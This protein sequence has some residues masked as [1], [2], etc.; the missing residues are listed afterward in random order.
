MIPPY[1]SRITTAKLLIES[2]EYEVK[3]LPVVLT[4]CVFGW[5][6]CVSLQEGGMAFVCVCVPVCV[7]SFLVN[8]AEGGKAMPGLFALQSLVSIIEEWYLQ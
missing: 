6:E 4:R 3:C 7:V 1:E 8:S 5:S 2:E